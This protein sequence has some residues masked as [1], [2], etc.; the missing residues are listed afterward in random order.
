MQYPRVILTLEDTFPPI[1]E[2][3]MTTDFVDKVRREIYL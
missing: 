2:Y 1:T 3:A